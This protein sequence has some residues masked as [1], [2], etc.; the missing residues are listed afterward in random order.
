MLHSVS[1]RNKLN[2]RA[3]NLTTVN[4]YISTLKMSVLFF[5][6][7]WRSVHIDDLRRST[8]F[9]SDVDSLKNQ[10]ISDLFKDPPD[11]NS[12]KNFFPKEYYIF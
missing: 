1:T 9:V 4:T 8:E 7:P 12:S 3:D 11:G 6:G 2:E 10:R 5:I